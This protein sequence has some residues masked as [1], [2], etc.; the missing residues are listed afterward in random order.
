MRVYLCSKKIEVINK[1]VHNQ[2][3]K[4][5]NYGNDYYYL[6]LSLWLIHQKVYIQQLRPYVVDLH[7]VEFSFFS[8]SSKFNLCELKC[9]QLSKSIQG[10]ECFIKWKHFLKKNGNIKMLLTKC[11]NAFNQRVI[12]VCA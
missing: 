12:S 3:S 8:F 11:P 4:L 6:D 5:T 10:K 1:K 7:I 2:S 9:N